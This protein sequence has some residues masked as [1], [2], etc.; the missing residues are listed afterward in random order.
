MHAPARSLRNVRS[1]VA[2]AAA[3]AL[4]AIP[5]ASRAAPRAVSAREFEEA[6]AVVEQ[7]AGVKGEPA[8]IGGKAIPPSEARAFPVNGATAERVLRAHHA[9]LRER[10]VYLFRLERAFGIAGEKDPLVL[11]RNADRSAVVRRVGT[12]GP[13]VGVTTE[14]IVAWLEALEKD[15]PFLLT[16]IGVDYLAGWFLSP[17]KDPEAMARRCVALAPDLVSARPSRLD[18]LVEEIR[19]NGTLYLIW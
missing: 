11:L 6:V 3:I 4:L 14:R 19:V 1:P 16:E 17:P 15:E 12:A 7:A 9:R 2:L 13:K 18:L 10:G 5:F 8:V